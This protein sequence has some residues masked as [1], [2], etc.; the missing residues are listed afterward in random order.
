MASVAPVGNDS[1]HKDDLNVETVESVE[2]LQDA[3]T[4]TGR[5][6]SRRLK[7]TSVSCKCRIINLEFR[8]VLSLN[9][10]TSIYS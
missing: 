8:G 3:G 7:I 1:L 6:P 9:S 5:N 10:V 4:L 2:I